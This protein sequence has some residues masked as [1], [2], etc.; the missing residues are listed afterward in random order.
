MPDVNFNLQWDATGE[1][2]YETGIRRAVLYPQH[3]DGTYPKGVVWNGVT[4]VTE[5]PTGAEA[6]AKY[7]DDIKY[8]NLYSLEE[9]EATLK[10]YTFPDEFYECDGTAAYTEGMYIGQQERKSFGLCYRTAIGNEIDGDK[11]GYK[12]HIVYGAKAS[13]SERDYATIND[14][15]E[16]I[17]FSWEIKTVP[18]DVPG[19]KPTATVVIDATKFEPEKIA[20]LEQVLYGTAATTGANPTPAVEARLPLPAEIKDILTSNG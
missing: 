6:T 1:H 2:L 8:L 16:A 17:E 5:K 13:P 20:A 7:A 11:H 18:V 10:A 12:I 4:G 19:F 14:S 15:P 3:S 9:F